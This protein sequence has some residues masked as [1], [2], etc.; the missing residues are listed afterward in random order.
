MLVTIPI[1]A[2]DDGGSVFKITEVYHV[3]CEKNT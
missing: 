1:V 3:R 2:Y